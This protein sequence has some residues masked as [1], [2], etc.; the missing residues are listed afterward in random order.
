MYTLL[1]IL[2]VSSTVRAI[3]VCKQKSTPN[4]AAL[5]VSGRVVSVSIGTTALRHWVPA[6]AVQCG[7]CFVAQTET[8]PGESLS[9][10]TERLTPGDQPQSEVRHVHHYADAAE[11]RHSG[12]GSTVGAGPA[13]SYARSD[14]G[15]TEVYFGRRTCLRTS[16]RLLPQSAKAWSR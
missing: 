11:A 10:T 8:T 7:D 5:F 12:R 16:R 4:L 1:V 3:N 14:T 6:S 9:T 13:A 15:D 2:S